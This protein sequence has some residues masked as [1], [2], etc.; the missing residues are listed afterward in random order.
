MS[1]IVV[2]GTEPGVKHSKCVNGLR[3]LAG[4]SKRQ[5]DEILSRLNSGKERGWQYNREMPRE[6]AEVGAEH[7]T[8]YYGLQTDV[9]ETPLPASTKL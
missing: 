5:A 4:L 2:T 6:N 7:L 1:Y 3:A 8:R 9:R